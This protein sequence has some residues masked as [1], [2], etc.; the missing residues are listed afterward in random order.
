V[1][2]YR[3]GTLSRADRALQA[4]EKAYREGAASL[5]ALLEAERT[6]IALRQD[7]LDTLYEL[8][9]ARLELERSAGLPPSSKSL[10]Q[11]S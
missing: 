5:L 8:R 1:A 2:R 3:G 11:R 10:E 6:Y 7:Y 9:V 4:A